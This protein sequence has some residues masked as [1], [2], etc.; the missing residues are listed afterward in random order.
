MFVVVTSLST[1]EVV[2]ACHHDDIFPGLDT[3]AAIR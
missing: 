2:E 3:V 1:Y